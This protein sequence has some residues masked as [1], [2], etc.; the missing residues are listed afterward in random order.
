MRNY[1]F[2]CHPF[3]AQSYFN[4]F[5]EEYEELDGGDEICEREEVVNGEDKIQDADRPPKFDIPDGPTEGPL[6]DVA[7]IAF[8]PAGKQRLDFCAVE[9]RFYED[10]KHERVLGSMH[11]VPSPLHKGLRYWKAVP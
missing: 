1:L 7:R 10:Q 6:T 5:K 2:R 8:K 4:P 9:V 3:A 11:A